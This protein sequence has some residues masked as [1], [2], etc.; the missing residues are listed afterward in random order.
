MAWSFLVSFH[1]KYEG[2]WKLPRETLF[3]NRYK[4]MYIC[5]FFSFSVGPVT[6][7]GHGN[8]A[9]TVMWDNQLLDPS[10]IISNAYKYWHAW[11]PQGMAYCTHLMKVH[12]GSLYFWLQLSLY[13]CRCFT[14]RTDKHWV[15]SI[16]C[17]S[18][19]SFC[20]QLPFPVKKNAGSSHSIYLKV[21]LISSRFL[22]LWYHD[23]FNL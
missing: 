1:L 9:L 2:T 3:W 19:F 17:Y 4:Y 7:F 22:L 5:S 21:L 15:V 11:S 8:A 18:A 10:L 12:V 23:W 6:L 20:F 14:V 13:T 16:F